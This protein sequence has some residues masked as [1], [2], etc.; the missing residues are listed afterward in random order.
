MPI[1]HNR[2]TLLF[3]I[4]AALTLSA[5]GG[6]SSDNPIHVP[7]LTKGLCFDNGIYASGASYKL[8]FKEGT[9]SPVVSGSVLAT[10]A[11]FNGVPDL[12]QFVETTSNTVSIVVTRYLKPLSPQAAFTQPSSVVALYGTEAAQGSQSFTTTTYT[13]PYE[14]RRVELGVGETRTF[15]GQGTRTEMFPPNSG[16]H[17]RQDQVKFVGVESIT[18]PAGTFTACRYEVNGNT[19][20]WLHRSLVVRRDIS[21]GESRILQSGELNGTPLKSQ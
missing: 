10:N 18:L 16:P 13:P 8:N 21:G 6:G 9:A 14:D 4:S 12:V 17:T 15:T 19:T 3:V 5:C 20:E 2:S 1:L 11:S 7:E